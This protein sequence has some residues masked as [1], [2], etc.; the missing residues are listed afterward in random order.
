MAEPSSRDKP[1]RRSEVRVPLPPAALS[2]LA[3][4]VTRAAAAP[5]TAKAWI[6]SAVFLLPPLLLTG[7][8]EEGVRGVEAEGRR[9]VLG[10]GIAWL[11]LAAAAGAVAV[12]VRRARDRVENVDPSVGAL[13][14]WWGSTLGITA[15]L[16]AAFGITWVAFRGVLEWLADNA[17]RSPGFAETFALLRVVPLALAGLMAAGLAALAVGVT[18]M[19]AIRAVEGCA[20]GPAAS[21]LRALWRKSRPRLLL[22]AS[23]AGISAGAAYFAM[24]YVVAAVYGWAGLPPAPGEWSSL[25]YDHALRTALV[26]TPPLAILGSAGVGSHLLLRSL[27]GPPTA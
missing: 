21:I 17:S 22:H 23:V 25:L 5:F 4:E 8:L 2:P 11:H 1:T 26:W 20:T 16:P 12:H 9:R 3:P 24:E 27:N 14:R 15:G 18:W 13:V 7:L 19:T 6:V 10:F